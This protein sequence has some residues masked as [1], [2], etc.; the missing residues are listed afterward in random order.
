MA[1][2]AH[3][4]RSVTLV[5]SKHP[6]D[7]LQIAQPEGGDRGKIIPSCQPANC[8]GCGILFGFEE[9]RWV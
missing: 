4:E 1:P 5:G 7:R 8:R 3:M 2:A 9:T 6:L